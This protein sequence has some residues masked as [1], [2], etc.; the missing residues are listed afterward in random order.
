MLWRVKY[1][2]VKDVSK[3]GF[4]KLHDTRWISFGSYIHLR[5]IRDQIYS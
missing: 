1:R 4:G 2:F 3:P 5:G